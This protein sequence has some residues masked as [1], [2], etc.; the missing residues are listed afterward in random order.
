M[1]LY[2]PSQDYLRVTTLPHHQHDAMM[3]RG[4]KP[5]VN[6]MVDWLYRG[7]NVPFWTK[8][9]GINK[10]VK[11]FYR[12]TPGVY[13]VRADGDIYGYNAAVKQNDG[14]AP[15]LLKPSA[16]QP[17][18]HG[19]YKVMD[20]DPESRDNAYLHTL[21][22][23]YNQG[24]GLPG[25]PQR[26][27]RDYLVRVEPGSDELLLGKAYYRLGPILVHTN[28]FVLERMCRA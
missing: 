23:D 5:D 3:V 19:Y 27:I 26:G 11:G 25:D 1:S 17:F 20:V 4:E 13:Q 8:L 14:A 22:L 10:F 28:Y 15:W 7:K 18:R 6:A 9:V 24:G 16:D 21:L 12:G 2:K